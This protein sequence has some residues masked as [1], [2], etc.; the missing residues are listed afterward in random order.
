MIGTYAAIVG[1]SSSICASIE[2]G[3]MDV[4]RDLSMYPQE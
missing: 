4:T 1:K 3:F 2:V